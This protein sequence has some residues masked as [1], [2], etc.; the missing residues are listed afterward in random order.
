MYR[1]EQ[2]LAIFLAGY[3]CS[4]AGYSY[5]Y[6]CCGFGFSFTNSPLSN[7]CARHLDGCSW[8]HGFAYITPEDYMTT[9]PHNLTLTGTNIVQV[10]LVQDENI[11]EFGLSYAT[12]VRGA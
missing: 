11:T 7:R 5:S 4:V 8:H 1:L 2:I 3:N 6:Y 9:G 12:G 10:K